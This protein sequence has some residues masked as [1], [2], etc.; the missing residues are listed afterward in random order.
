MPE[1]STLNQVVQIGVESTAGTAVAPTTVLAAMSIEP[2]PTAQV[3]QFR[4][5]GQKYRSLTALGKEWTE[6]AL[7]GRLTYNEIVIPFSSAIDTATIHRVS[8]LSLS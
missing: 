2:S 1:R 4:P 8:P 3:D 5:A 6:A 7:S